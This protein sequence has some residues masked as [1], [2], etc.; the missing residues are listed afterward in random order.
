M[1]QMMITIP[2]FGILAISRIPFPAVLITV[3]LSTSF[4]VMLGAAHVIGMLTIL[5]GIVSR[6]ISYLVGGMTE[7]SA[8]VV[9]LARVLSGSIISKV[10]L[11]AV[12][13]C[14]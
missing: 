14:G 10:V 12:V 1:V 3:P 2:F 8:A 5:A 13:A 4:V 7:E 11:S 6:S 9:G